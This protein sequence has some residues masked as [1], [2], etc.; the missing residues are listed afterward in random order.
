ME[1]HQGISL[2]LYFTSD[3]HSQ[4]MSLITDINQVVSDIL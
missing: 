2:F 3:H 1:D 4:S